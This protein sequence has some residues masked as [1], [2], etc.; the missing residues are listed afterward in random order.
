MV[1]PTPPTSE[2]R[3]RIVDTEL[4]VLLHDL[5]AV[6]LEGPKAVG[7]TSTATQRAATL[8]RFDDPT[9]LELV[10][11]HPTRVIQGTPPIVIDEWQRYPASWDLVRRACDDPVTAPGTFILTGSATPSV[12]P[13]HT[14]AG[15]IVPVR[16]RPMTLPERAVSTPTVS[17]AHLL[18]GGRPTIDGT[19]AFTLPEY[20]DEILAGGFPGMRLPEGRARRAILDG[21]IARIV[22]T[23]LPEIGVSIR[24]PATLHR[25]LRAYAAAISTTTSHEKIRDAASAGEGT[26]PARSTTIPYREALERLWILDPVP[27]WAPTSNHL[28]KLTAAPKHQLA[29]PALAARLLGLDAGALLSG[30]GPATVVR[31]GTFLGALFESLCTLSTRVFAQ[32]AE[33]T[34]GHLRTRA[35]EREVDLIVVRGDQ[36]VVAIEVKLSAT[37]SD[38]HVAHLR[39]LQTKLGDDLLDS[40]VL[41]TGPHA[42]RRPD[43]IAVVPLALLGP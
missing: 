3:R 42:Y 41:T 12:R 10:E 13:T 11:A 5:P 37:V 32:A 34:V 28:A 19:T 23:E 38:D 15:R 31:D 22:D 30:K 6:S 25:W 7:K 18:A 33:A 35:G 26:T 20:A 4:D 16:V 17:L 1:R 2:Y 29:D 43:G 36:R 39:W 24:N 8:T 40:I 27:A 14:G 9:S 21:Y